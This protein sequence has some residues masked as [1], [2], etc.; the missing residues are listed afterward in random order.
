MDKTNEVMIAFLAWII[1]SV[2]IVVATRKPSRLFSSFGARTL[3]A[4]ASLLTATLALNFYTTMVYADYFRY[5]ER[6][7]NFNNELLDGYALLSL[8][9]LINF[10]TLCSGVFGASIGG[11]LIYKAAYPQN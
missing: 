10:T 6:M 2:L 5:L 1:V 11:S 3:L 9:N 7:A 4:G 8:Q